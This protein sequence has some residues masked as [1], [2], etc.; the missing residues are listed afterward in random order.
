[1][2]LREDCSNTWRLKP[3]HASLTCISTKEFSRP[4]GILS[5]RIQSIP[6]PAVEVAVKAGQVT[7]VEKDFFLLHHVKWREGGPEN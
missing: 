3:H 6:L 2:P 7:E 1:M 5:A 4:K